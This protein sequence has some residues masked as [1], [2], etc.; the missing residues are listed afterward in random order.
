MNE[1][2]WQNDKP[3]EIRTIAAGR[4]TYENPA[5][6]S[7]RFQTRAVNPDPRVHCII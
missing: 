4:S 6:E 3:I 5:P 2:G 7:S 1:T